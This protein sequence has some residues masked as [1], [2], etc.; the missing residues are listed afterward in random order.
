MFSLQMKLANGIVALQ[1]NFNSNPLQ[2][3]TKCAENFNSQQSNND[4]KN[5][6]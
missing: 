5:E 6:R 3:K 1:E 4:S 2:S